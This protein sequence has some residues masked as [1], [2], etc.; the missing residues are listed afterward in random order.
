MNNEPTDWDAII[1]DPDLSFDL[2]LIS[3][4]ELRSKIVTMSDE[5]VDALHQ[6]LTQALDE[7]NRRN[8]I[9]NQ[10]LAVG[11]IATTIMTVV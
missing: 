7:T 5:D 3:E 8:A 9:I 10:I 1:D 6:S 11:K 2:S 4:D